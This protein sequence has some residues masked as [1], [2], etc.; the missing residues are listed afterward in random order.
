[1]APKG[2][3]SPYHANH[4]FTFP[5]DFLYSTCSFKRMPLLIFYLFFIIFSFHLLPISMSSFCDML[6][7]TL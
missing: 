4:K 1:M 5:N 3:M 7:I 6:R 2:K